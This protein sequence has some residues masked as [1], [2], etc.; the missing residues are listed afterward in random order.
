VKG[1]EIWLIPPRGRMALLGWV[2]TRFNDSRSSRH[3]KKNLPGLFEMLE[4]S[5]KERTDGT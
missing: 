2:E 1:Q 5:D 4:W 3:A